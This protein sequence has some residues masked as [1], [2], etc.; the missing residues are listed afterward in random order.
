MKQVAILGAVLLMMAS[1]AQSQGNPAS[2]QQ[3][4]SPTAAFS[5]AAAVTADPGAGDP[6]PAEPAP[7]G[8]YG[9]LQNYNWQAYV[10]FSHI[11]F[12]ELPGVTG[13][14]NGFNMSLVYYPHSGH[15]AGDGE[16]VTGFAPQDG[17][18]THL[19]MGLGG[20]RYRVDV[21]H[22]LEVWG[23]GMVGGAHF[24]PQTAFGS[25]DAFAFDIGGGVDLNP[26][27]KRLG[28]RGQVDW[29]PT[30]FFGTHQYNVR[31]SVGIVY[32]F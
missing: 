5:L 24:Y 6:L 12:Y 2:S 1:A 8:V 13:Q 4:S 22:G 7:Q 27:H 17:V 32:R 11:S 31:E 23:H 29:T 19:A 21:G 15:W 14:L 26:H 30:L 16:F 9:V 28:F 10:G 18:N 25:Q 3:F 20:V